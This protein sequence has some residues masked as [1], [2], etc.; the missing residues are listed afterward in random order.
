MDWQKIQNEYYQG[1]STA[2]LGRKYGYSQQGVAKRLKKM[3]TKMRPPKPYKRYTVDPAVFETLTEEAAYWL[4]MLITDGCVHQPSRGGLPKVM[5]ELKE[6]DK[7]HVQYFS[8]FIKSTYPLYYNKAASSWKCQVASEELANVLSDYN[9][10]P[11]KT[12][13]IEAPESLLDNRHFWRGVIDGDGYVSGRPQLELASGSVRL[14]EQFI[15][16]VYIVS[17]TRY[18]NNGTQ[19]QTKVSITYNGHGCARVRL[20]GGTAE[21]VLKHLYEDASIYLPR[22]YNKISGILDKKG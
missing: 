7:D 21:R 12:N 18:N 16:F 1:L 20:D 2:L 14:L 4:G 11:R 19:R 13:I 6:E 5:L 9:I 15:E 22:K 10:V 8:D 17:P 3:G